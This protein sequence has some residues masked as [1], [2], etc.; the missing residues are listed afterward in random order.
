MAAD[1]PPAEPGGQQF[2]DGRVVHTG[3]VSEAVSPR[4]GRAGGIFKLL[5]LAGR[6][7]WIRCQDLQASS[8]VCD[9]SL[10]GLAQV[11]PKA[12]PV[13]DLHSLW[14]PGRRTFGEERCTIAADHLHP[15]PF[16][17]PSGQAG[18][19]PAGQ[20]SDWTPAFDVDQDGPVVAP[21]AGRVLIDA[22]YPRGRDFGVG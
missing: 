14:C 2:V 11:V 16:H 15:G 10:R 22:D 19:L 13:R 9:A 3:A 20:Q 12:P 18:R 8:V 4:P 6:L 17:K 1:R 7:S 5:R 21:F